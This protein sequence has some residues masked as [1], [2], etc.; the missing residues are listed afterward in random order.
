MRAVVCF[1]VLAV[2][3]ATCPAGTHI[4]GTGNC[5]SSLPEGAGCCKCKAGTFNEAEDRIACKDC[6]VGRF[7]AAVR[8]TS[9]QTCSVCTAGWYH[10]TDQTAYATKVAATVQTDVCV[11]CPLGT[12][13]SNANTQGNAASSCT[14]C[15]A[16]HYSNT[17]TAASAGDCIKCVNETMTMKK[18]GGAF[19]TGAT[20]EGAACKARSHDC[21]MGEWGE[22]SRCSLMCGGGYQT[23]DRVLVTDASSIE[24]RTSKGCATT[25]TR[26]C[27]TAPCSTLNDRYPSYTE[28]GNGLW[29]EIKFPD[30]TPD[31][32]GLPNGMNAECRRQKH[33]LTGPWRFE[34]LRSGVQNG[35]LIGEVV[36]TENKPVDGWCC[37]ITT[38]EHV[39]VG[40]TICRES[41]SPA[42]TGNELVF[43][44]EKMDY[45]PATGQLCVR[46]STSSCGQVKPMFVHKEVCQHTTCAVEVHNCTLYDCRNATRGNT[47]L[48]GFC[49][50]QGI[51]ACDGTMHTTIRVQ[52]PDHNDVGDADG[53]F[54]HVTE[55][56]TPVTDSVCTCF[57]LDVYK[58]QSHLD[59]HRHQRLAD[60]TGVSAQAAWN[61]GTTYQ[62]KIGDD[63]NIVNP[64]FNHQDTQT[65]GDRYVD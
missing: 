13:N 16:G 52:H 29:W 58:R 3:L 54:C 23:R 64:H 21:V 46:G 18:V 32:S 43:L 65:H 26:R 62:E 15:A 37:K 60:H 41:R 44:D 57:C 40:E 4:K 12:F 17:A 31:G 39:R 25:D 30:D 38:P 27:N 35:Y 63:T 48:G 34:S 2:A 50:N 53:H 33:D 42:P 7:S 9:S 5:P 10:P 51:G 20:S 1:A 59:S 47:H 8:A 45:N 11:A 49:P 61:S 56:R 55:H 24:A 14:K 6:M 22:F 19:V 36:H 28:L